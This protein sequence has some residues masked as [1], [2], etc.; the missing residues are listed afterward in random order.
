MNNVTAQSLLKR[1]FRIREIIRQGGL[2]ENATDHL[3]RSLRSVIVAIARIQPQ[4]ADDIS[5][6]LRLARDLVE[7]WRSD[8]RLT[9]GVLA[10]THKQAANIVYQD[11]ESAS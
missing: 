4:N 8:P 1:Y 6:K 3:W 5:A 11:K 10:L 2:P 7:D 9:M